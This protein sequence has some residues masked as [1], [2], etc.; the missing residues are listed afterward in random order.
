VAARTV[1]LPPSMKTGK[2]TFVTVI[3]KENGALT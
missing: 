1:S 2:V 3:S